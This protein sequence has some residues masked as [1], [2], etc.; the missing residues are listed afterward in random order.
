MAT[1]ATTRQVHAFDLLDAVV[2]AFPALPTEDQLALA[3]KIE[4]DA[5]D[6]RDENVSPGCPDPDAVLPMIQESMLNALVSQQVSSHDPLEP[7]I[8]LVGRIMDAVPR[9]DR[10][11]AELIAPFVYQ[12]LEMLV[13]T[14][15]ADG[16]PDDKLNEFD[17]F[18]DRNEQ[19]VEDWF[20]E[21]LPDYESR[22]DFL[23]LVAA[24]PD[25]ER[26]TV[27]SEYGATRWLHLNCP[28]YQEVTEACASL[29]RTALQDAVIEA[30][31]DGLNTWL[32]FRRTAWEGAF[33]GVDAEQIMAHVAA[34]VHKEGPDA[35][36]LWA[37]TQY[38]LDTLFERAA[39]IG[40][41]AQ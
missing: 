17:F 41:E 35:F 19:G 1:I 18:L 6:Y 36:V 7:Q 22:D 23:A 32:R 38:A 21:N 24:N 13:G 39:A 33:N 2:A 15:L 14:R 3:A 27:L 40:G 20:A 4:R 29:M 12:G 16:M 31:S 5:H 30:G 10:E 11:D 8:D 25:A 9:M 37:Q 28:D 34:I 26:L